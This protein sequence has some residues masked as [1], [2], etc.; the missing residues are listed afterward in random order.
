MKQALVGS[1]LVLVVAS[2]VSWWFLPIVQKPKT[3]TA[4]PETK[5][6]VD[7]GPIPFKPPNP[8]SDQ[9]FNPGWIGSACRQDQDCAYAGGFCL[10]PEE[11]FP[12]GTCTQRCQRFCPD[13]KGDLFS[14]TLCAEDPAYGDKGLCFAG[15]NLHLTASGCRPGYVCTTL[16]RI[17]D[18][19]VRLVCLPQRGSS[20]PPTACTRKLLASGL[21][22][23]R[24][25]LADSPVRP[26]RPG[27]P[28]PDHDIC[29]IDTPVLL[30][31]PI[32][33]VDYRQKG[34]RHADHLLVACRL[35]LALDRLSELLAAASVVEV[36]HNGTYVC[37]SVAGT[38]SLSGHG[39]A[40][41]ID[42]TGFELAQDSPVSIEAHWNSPD[43]KKRNFLRKLTASIRK[44]RIFD[45]VLTPNADPSH[46]DHL[47]LEI[48]FKN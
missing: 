16:R 28:E 8:A 5:L 31:S 43:K 40:L 7:A 9:N 19:Q 13:R 44:A 41:A 34:Q 20:A 6:S 32:Q 12:H 11:G 45:V 46:R 25:D 42:I 27:D 26:A 36:E 30:A 3:P 2:A 1:L 33:T 4:P 18:S 47:H 24:P 21:H 29:Q 23:T 39:H 15:C 17:D 37:R 22:F 35:A 10:L 38:R 48:K 14:V